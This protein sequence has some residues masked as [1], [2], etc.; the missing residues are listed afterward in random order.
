MK[1]VRAPGSRHDY[2][3]DREAMPV[4]GGSTNVRVL[5]LPAQE[6]EGD[7]AVCVLCESSM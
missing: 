5:S 7:L 4:L 6:E 2:Q 1:Q 3:E